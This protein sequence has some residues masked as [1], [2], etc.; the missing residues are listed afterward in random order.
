MGDASVTAQEVKDAVEKERVRLVS[1]NAAQT[2]N[3]FACAACDAGLNAT[4]A[5]VILAAIQ[6]FQRTHQQLRLSRLHPVY[7]RPLLQ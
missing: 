4:L 3:W 6:A 5:V 1:E 2:A 7:L